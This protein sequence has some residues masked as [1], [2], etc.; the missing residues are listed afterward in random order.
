MIKSSPKSLMVRRIV[1]A[2]LQL[3]LLPLRASARLALYAKG[4]FISHE[5]H[6]LITADVIRRKFP[7]HKGLIVDVGT[8]D[9]DSAIFFATRFKNR[10]IGFEPNPTAY[11]KAHENVARFSHVEVVNLGLSDS[12][13][14][15][16]FYVSK[17]GDSSSLLAIKD[18][19]EIELEK[20]ITV[21]VTTL[22]I[23]LYN[24]PE[25]LLLKLDVQGAELN[26]LKGGVETLKRTKLVLTE[27]SIAEMYHNTCLYYDLDK[28]LR[29]NGFKIHTLITNYNNE[30]TKYFDILYIKEN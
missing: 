17:N 7:E 24:H 1:D 12:V 15:F 13:G 18:F 4:K 28:M 19:S 6:F 9:G 3:Y 2:I 10:V 20:K 16:D 25:I 27:V 14:Q 29:D 23:F 30:G 11:A 5:E 26:L 21:S 8:Y 22:D